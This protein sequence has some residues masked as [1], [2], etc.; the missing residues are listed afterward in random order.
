MPFNEHLI[1]S[2]KLE[3]LGLSARCLTSVSA[4]VQDLV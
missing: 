1:K 4:V 3:P 2:A